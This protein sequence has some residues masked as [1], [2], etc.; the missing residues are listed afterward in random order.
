[1]VR[2]WVPVWRAL[3]HE[4][5]HVDQAVQTWMQSTSHGAVLQLR[6]FSRVVGHATPPKSALTVMAIQTL[7][8][9]TRIRQMTRMERRVKRTQVFWRT[10]KSSKLILRSVEAASHLKTQLSTSRLA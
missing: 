8:V 6:V 2:F 4:R 5:V 9:A 10:T 3:L 7:L 1:M